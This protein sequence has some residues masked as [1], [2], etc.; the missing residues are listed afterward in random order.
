MHAR[1]FVLALSSSLLA[2]QT[3]IEA[4]GSTDDTGDETAASTTAAEEQMC[5]V[6]ANSLEVGGVCWCEPGTTWVEPFNPS[7]FECAPLQPREGECD[8]VNGAGSTGACICVDYYAWCSVTNEADTDCCY[9]PAQDPDGS[10]A[11]PGETSSGETSTGDTDATS[12]GD[13]DATSTGDTD[14]TTTGTESGT[15][16]TSSTG[17]GSTGSSSSSS[18]A[19]G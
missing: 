15:D 10:H 11:P 5:G 3:G 12:T 16:D 14:A 7:S 6:A 18:G 1:L 19:T 17:A 13:T 8:P 2:C 9:D 4:T